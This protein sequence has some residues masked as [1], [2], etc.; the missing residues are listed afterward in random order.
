MFKADTTELGPAEDQDRGKTS[1][2]SNNNI[3]QNDIGSGN[4]M[5]DNYN[6]DDF[7]LID[8]AGNQ[9]GMFLGEMIEELDFS[10]WLTDDDDVSRPNDNAEAGVPATTATTRST[11]DTASIPSP[12]PITENYVSHTTN[13][14]RKNS[15]SDKRA[16]P[17][18]MIGIHRDRFTLKRTKS[19][20]FYSP[21]QQIRNLV[22]KKKGALGSTNRFTLQKSYSSDVLP[23]SEQ[24]VNVRRT[25]STTNNDNTKK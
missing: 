5:M 4:L 13:S 12:L 9:D 23:L 22:M 3:Q 16:P 19:N 18:N 1:I 17:D 7:L 15:I 6:A 21:S 25:N 14:T 10:K 8:K 24:N 2:P 20:P 11:I